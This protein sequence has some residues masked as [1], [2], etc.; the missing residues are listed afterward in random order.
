LFVLFSHE[1][2]G[3]HVDTDC[4]SEE[5]EAEGSSHA[6]EIIKTVG[7]MSEALLDLGYTLAAGQGER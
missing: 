3:V 6:V 2:D 4:S 5:S 7:E 1:L